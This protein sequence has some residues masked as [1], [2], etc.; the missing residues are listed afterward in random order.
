AC[1]PSVGYLLRKFA[2]R[3]KRPLL[4]AS[5]VLLALVAGI[6][7]T[8]LGLL[9]AQASEELAQNEA[10]KAGQERDRANRARDDEARSHLQAEANFL[11]TLEAVD[12]LLT[13]VSDK[14]LS[15][16]PHLE[17]VRR[18]LLE[19][20][21]KFFEDFLQAKRTDRTVRFEAG[22]A[23]RRVGDIRMLLGAR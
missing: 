14:E 11:K 18:R 2:R 23:Y 9:R 13:E 17:P 21:L 22:L 5:L 7:G 19:K 20:A 3:H 10:W 4:A 8:T 15:S 12:Q 6:I 1:P 16:I